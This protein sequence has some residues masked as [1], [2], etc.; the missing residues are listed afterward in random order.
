MTDKLVAEILYHIE[1]HRLNPQR[2]TFIGH[3]LG[4][5]LIRAAIMRPQ[6]K[7]H[8]SKFYTFLSLSGP[9]L[10][11]LYNQSGLVNMGKFYT[12]VSLLL[13]GFLII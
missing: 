7:P 2:I 13:K 10:G 1:I 4:T 9:H 3:S 8:R 6:L 11:T 5:L 12:I